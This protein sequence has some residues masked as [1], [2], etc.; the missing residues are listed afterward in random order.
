MYVLKSVIFLGLWQLSSGQQGLS[1]CYFLDNKGSKYEYYDYQA[2]AALNYYGKTLQDTNKWVVGSTTYNVILRHIQSGFMKG[3]NGAA[4]PLVIG[5]EEKKLAYNERLQEEWL[6]RALEEHEAVEDC[7][8]WITPSTTYRGERMR[9]MMF[10]E[11]LRS[12]TADRLGIAPLR[13]P[14]ITSPV[15]APT[16]PDFSLYDPAKFPNFYG[17]Y[18][19][20]TNA[21]SG[22]LD[23]LYDLYNF[24]TIA[25]IYDY[26]GKKE[27]SWN[28]LSRM[29]TPDG[30]LFNQ[31]TAK[32][33]YSAF[34]DD[35]YRNAQ[36]AEPD[37]PSPG[38][39]SE[40]RPNETL[41]Y[42]WDLSFGPK[43]IIFVHPITVA[44]Q[45]ALEE[46]NIYHGMIINDIYVAGED[47]SSANPIK[48]YLGEREALTSHYN[49]V[50]LL[51][52]IRDLNYLSA[53]ALF[54]LQNIQMITVRGNCETTKNMAECFRQGVYDPCSDI[55]PA[56]MSQCTSLGP[57][58]L[59]VE[60]WFGRATFGNNQANRGYV[61][62]KLGSDGHFHVIK[63]TEIIGERPTTF[64]DRRNEEQNGVLRIVIGVLVILAIMGCLVGIV[65]VRRTNKYLVIR[66]SATLFLQII[67][68][69]AIILYASLLW[70][71]VQI[72]DL[73]CVGF[74]WF[75]YL[76]WAICFTA[77]LV[78]TYRVDQVFKVAR[79]AHLH[80]I[81]LLRV[82]YTPIVA[83]FLLYLILWTTFDAPI[84]LQERSGS[85][86]YLTCDIQ[87]IGMYFG[88]TMQG[89]MMVWAAVLAFR[90]RNVPSSF[91]E[92]AL[93]SAS[94]YNWTVIQAV[95]LVLMFIMEHDRDVQLILMFLY[96]YV[97]V[98]TMLIMMLLPKAWAIYRGKGND[99]NS[100]T[101]NSSIISGISNSPSAGQKSVRQTE[102]STDETPEDHMAD[103]RKLRAEVGRLVHDNTKL[104]HA[105]QQ[106]LHPSMDEIEPS[107]GQQ[108]TE[109]LKRG[110]ASEEV[111]SIS[112]TYEKAG[113]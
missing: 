35:V 38:D 11:T 30:L 15:M 52:G 7:D 58:K 44:Q 71:I 21:I 93:I 29:Y 68:F 36:I 76:G 49:E 81:S 24:R 74:A 90:V 41:Q 77:L 107:N 1:V 111:N 110:T 4:T 42:L 17:S 40:G 79:K 96:V 89:A 104:S 106:V 27:R 84:A 50:Q 32:S 56:N 2:H 12:L 92:A 99:I 94:V 103:V 59:D 53:S 5:D 102:G 9:N 88:Q 97:P 18:P 33:R 39:A 78:K 51:K 54:A 34:V 19:A 25:Y 86:T 23:R 20:T 101:V 109:T 64:P 82:M 73:T 61:Y 62:S 28:V 72:N 108:S 87:S 91:N 45:K 48:G 8:F 85:V 57:E 47:I 113:Q 65:G 13:K 100:R 69:G 10:N 95:V 26:I 6:L 98:T 3:G 67:L 22:V 66:S 46:Q 16:S 31:A 43:V 70:L 80:D 105:L 14:V 83:S 60:T 75:M 37:D 112:S 55:A 63:T